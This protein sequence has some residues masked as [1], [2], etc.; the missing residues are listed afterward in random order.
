MR[1]TLSHDHRSPVDA[2]MT[3]ISTRVFPTTAGW[4]VAGTTEP[5]ATGYLA[6]RVA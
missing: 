4:T 2:H 3:V 6:F 5:S 1:L